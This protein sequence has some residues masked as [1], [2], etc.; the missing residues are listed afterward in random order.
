MSEYDSKY[1]KVKDEIKELKEKIKEERQKPSKDK[2]KIKM[3]KELLKDKKIE[4]KD[5]KRHLA[6]EKKNSKGN[7]NK[8]HKEENDTIKDLPEEPDNTEELNENEL[9]KQE[10]RDEISNNKE[11]EDDEKPTST[12]DFKLTLVDWQIRTG[13][14]IVPDNY[15]KYRNSK[16]LTEQEFR[17]ILKYENVP[18]IVREPGKAEKYLKSEEDWNSIRTSMSSL[19]QAIQRGD[20]PKQVDNDD[21]ILLQ[22]SR[23]AVRDENGDGYL[24]LDDVSAKNEEQSELINLQSRMPEE[25]QDNYRFVG[26]KDSSEKV[27]HDILQDNLTR[28]ILESYGLD[29]VSKGDVDKVSAYIAHDLEESEIE[30]PGGRDEEGEIPIAPPPAY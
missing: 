28:S 15:I 4:L 18:K 3:L 20:F 8:K 14:E 19:K 25:I 26:A 29:D 21:Y 13:I 27:L 22:Y 5:V 1:E 12:Y 9:G 6:K 24:N 16:F 10:K 7:D 17:D 2:G 11:Q 23:D 30:E